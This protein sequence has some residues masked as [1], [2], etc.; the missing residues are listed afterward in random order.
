[1]PPNLTRP[2]GTATALFD[3]LENPPSGADL[4]ARSAKGGAP[5]PYPALCPAQRHK[6]RIGPFF[7]SGSLHLK[8]RVIRSNYR[9]GVGF[10]GRALVWRVRDAGFHAETQL[11]NEGI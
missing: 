4:T 6:D 11:T 5:S 9:T 10:K 3:P 2:K 8:Q 7:L 1:M